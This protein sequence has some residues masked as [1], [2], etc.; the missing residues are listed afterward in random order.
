MF[1]SYKRLISIRTNEAAFNPFGTFVFH[2]IDNRVFVIEQISIDGTERIMA[3]H[4]FADE[5]FTCKLPETLSLPMHDLLSPLELRDK[6]EVA[7]EPYQ[8]VWLKGSAN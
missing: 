8:I 4:N 5:A 7:L 2:H 3:L 1:E 6:R